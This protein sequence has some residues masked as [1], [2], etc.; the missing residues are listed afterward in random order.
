MEGVLY[1][2][3]CNHGVCICEDGGQWAA[4]CMGC[5]NQIGK[6]GYYD[7]CAATKEEAIQRWNHQNIAC[8]NHCHYQLPFGFVPEAGCEVHDI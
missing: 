6:P 5:D 2:R 1:C 4:H 3:D 8:G 7:P